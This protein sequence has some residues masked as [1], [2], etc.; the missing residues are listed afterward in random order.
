PVSPQIDLPFLPFVFD[1]SMGVRRG[2]NALRDQL[3]QEIEKRRPDI[4]RILDH[5]GVP[6]V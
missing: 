2:D 1:I 5:Y 3:D 4:E 6:R